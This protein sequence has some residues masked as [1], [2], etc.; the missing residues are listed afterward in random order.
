ML[1]HDLGLMTIECEFYKAEH[2][3]L[4]KVIRTNQ[5]FKL[6]YKRGDTILERLQTPSPFLRALLEGDDSRACNFHQNIRA[7][8]LALAFTSVSYTKD[9]YTDLSR[10]LHCFQIHGE[11]FH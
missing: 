4:E 3:I 7:Y 10:G 8:N 9:T 2:W 5:Q 6:C 11:L 1:A